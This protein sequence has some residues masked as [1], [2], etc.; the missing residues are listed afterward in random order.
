MVYQRVQNNSIR[1][2]SGDR[3][4]ACCVWINMGGGQWRW[5]CSPHFC[6]GGG[7][8]PQQIKNQ[9]LGD[10]LTPQ[11]M[12]QMSLANLTAQMQD[13]LNQANYQLQQSQN[14]NITPEAQQQAAQNAVQFQAEAAAIQA[15]LNL[16]PNGQANTDPVNFFT[17]T[18]NSFLQSFGNAL[19]YVLP[20]GNTTPTVNPTLTPGQTPGIL[21]T[22]QTQYA[23]LPLWAWLG[24]AGVGLNMLMKN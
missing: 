5:V 22:L 15:W 20:G 19:N 17:T 24:V 14:P 18:I 1:S 13:D 10:N 3:T 23:G 2:L 21:N 4:P 11:Q 6:G 12:S 9:L 8:N 7:Y 16:G